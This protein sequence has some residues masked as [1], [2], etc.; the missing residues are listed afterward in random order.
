MKH[1]YT[2]F[3]ALLV[4]VVS[5][6]AQVNVYQNEFSTAADK[7]RLTY[8]FSNAFTVNDP[9]VLN[10][11]GSISIRGNNGSQ[12]VRGYTGFIVLNDALTFSPGSQYTITLRTRAEVQDV[13][14][15]F[16][17]GVTVTGSNVTGTLVLSNKIIT[18]AV[19]RDIV[20][21]FNVSAASTERIG[22]YVNSIVNANNNNEYLH[23]DAIR[24]TRT[25]QVIAAPAV[26]SVSRC[27]AGDV[28]LVATGAPVAGRYNWYTAAG[29]FLTSTSGIYTPVLQNT[30]SFQVSAVSA[31]GCESP[32]V[33]VTATVIPKFSANTDFV[34]Q[35]ITVGKPAV[36]QLNSGVFDSNH[37]V[38]IRWE[39]YNFVTGDRNVIAV[40][41][42]PESGPASLQILSVED[43][44]Y[45]EA[46]IT[47]INGVCYDDYM[48]YATT[49]GVVSL[50]VELT[51]FKGQRNSHGVSLAWA[52]ASE[53][54]NKGFEVQTSSDGRN[55]K[56]VAFVESKVGTTSLTQNYSFTHKNPAA[57]TNY[58]RLRQVDFDGTFEFSKTI[59]VQ[60]TLAAASS[61]YPT[62]ATEQVTV[63]L[64]HTDE[65]VT[66][67]LSDMNGRQ[68][69]Q[70]QNPTEREL[71]LPVNN[72]QQGMYFVTVMTNNQKE[73][74]RFVKR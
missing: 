12:S 25:C 51:S 66:V 38:S 67:L 72:L 60:F 59:A 49:Q 18:S 26:Q 48:L 64:L 35:E 71:V 36:L 63:K 65:Q 69:L 47:V 30:T 10:S 74:F 54:D 1:I 5:A 57:G 21:T 15:Q 13:D 31:D 34:K 3:I 8:T 14:L 11:D 53:L 16:L 33:N 41:E 70:V 9:A 20:Y 17:R 39:A 29:S 43:N 62:M 2:L 24:V 42:A 45:Y 4:L 27:G 55:Y 44:T 32:R 37:G 68:V 52:T 58:Y 46:F 61:V 28:R 7:N 6:Q 23:I 56:T 19:Y 50:P 40:A 22:F 73:V